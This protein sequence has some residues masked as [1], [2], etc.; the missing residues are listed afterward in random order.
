MKNSVSGLR[1]ILDTEKDSLDVSRKVIT[2]ES[3]ECLGPDGLHSLPPGQCMVITALGIK[4]NRTHY[5]LI[6]TGGG[7]KWNSK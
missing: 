1:G 7:E 6:H 2:S 5:K 3:R 4:R